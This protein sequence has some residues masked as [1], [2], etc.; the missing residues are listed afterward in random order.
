MWFSVRVLDRTRGPATVDVALGAYALDVTLAELL[1]V[2]GLARAASLASAFAGAGPG[3]GI[4]V[5]DLD[6]VPVRLGAPVADLPLRTGSVLTIGGVP[7]SPRQSGP[8]RSLVELTRIA[9]PAC[10]LSVR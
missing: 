4:A 3:A 6:G 2:L 9:G 5:A 10:G 8:G 1:D 7:G